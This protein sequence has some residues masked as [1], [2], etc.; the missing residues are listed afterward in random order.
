MFNLLLSSVSLICLVNSAMAQHSKCAGC[1]SDLKE[2]DCA[3]GDFLQYDPKVLFGCCPVCRPG[4]PVP[5]KCKPPASCLADGSYAPVQCKGDLFTGR[6][7]CSDRRGNRIFGQMWRGQAKNMSCAC[8]RRR[9]ELEASE[10][11]AVTLHCTRTGD[12]EPLQCDNGLCWCAQPSSGQPTV[13]PVLQTNM[14]RLPCYNAVGM[15]ESYLRRCESPVQAL[16]EIHKE[17]SAHGTKYLSKSLTLCD[18]DGSYGAYKIQGTSAYC[19]G[20]DGAILGAWTAESS[21][22]AGM[23]CNCARDTSIYF[24]DA[25]MTVAETCESNGNYRTQQNIGDYWYCVD[26]DGYAIDCTA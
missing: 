18:Y 23:N 12:Y 14:K 19:T 10:K 6:C 15:G 9:A 22:V 16:V 2:S 3:K 25:G 24:P 26:T 21:K 4:I 8:S 17:Q 7:F 1:V 11:R 5:G 13:Q 20:R